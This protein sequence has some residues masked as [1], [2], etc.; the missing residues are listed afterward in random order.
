MHVNV[1]KMWNVQMKGET[2]C[3]LE[4]VMQ[5]HVTRIVQIKIVRYEACE[6]VCKVCKHACAHDQ[7]YI[8][9]V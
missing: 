3:C 8:V 5:V 6:M 7:T 1:A 9:H 2:L 4:R